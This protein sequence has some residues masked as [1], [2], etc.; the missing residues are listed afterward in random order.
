MAA[1]R[2]KT[3]EAAGGDLA[4]PRENEQSRELADL[5]N[6]LQLDDMSTGLGLEQPLNLV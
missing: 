1:K 6:R 3:A 2:R 5:F 4:R